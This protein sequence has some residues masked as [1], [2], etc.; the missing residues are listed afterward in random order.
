MRKLGALI[1]YICRAF[2]FR[3]RWVR[4]SVVS[5][6]REMKKAGTT[7]RSFDCD[8]YRVDIHKY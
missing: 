6:V 7:H 2:E 1:Y 8:G 4:I 3:D 5:H